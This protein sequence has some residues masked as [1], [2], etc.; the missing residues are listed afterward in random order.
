M[1]LLV[2][3]LSGSLVA[4]VGAIAFV[5]FYLDQRVRKEGFDVELLLSKVTGVA[6]PER[7]LESPF[8]TGFAGASAGGVESPFSSPLVGTSGRVED[9]PFSRPLGSAPAPIAEDSPFS[10]GPLPGSADAEKYE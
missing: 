5:L 10:S 6:V 2:T 8:S 4:P 3:F 7:E 9:S 1:T